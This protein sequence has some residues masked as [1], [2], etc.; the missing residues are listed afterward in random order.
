LTIKP[1]LTIGVDC[2]TRAE[3][4]EDAA[5]HV[6]AAEAGV[7]RRVRADQKYR[8]KMPISVMQKRA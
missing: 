1:S 7:M 6:G 3:K 8:L 4:R 2:C 5:E